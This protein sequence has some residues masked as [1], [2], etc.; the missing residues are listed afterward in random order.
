MIYHLIPVDEIDLHNAN[1]DCMCGVEVVNEDRLEE[2]SNL[3]GNLVYE[4][5]PFNPIPEV[6]YDLRV[7]E[8]LN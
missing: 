4:H 8:C 1:T 6:P 5:V 3:K 7:C 2:H